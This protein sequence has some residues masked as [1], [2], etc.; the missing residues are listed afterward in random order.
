MSDPLLSEKHEVLR[1]SVR[2]FS[3]REI[4]PLAADIDREAR[5]PWETADKMAGLGY[6]GIQAPQSL[7]GAGL[8]TVSY[9]IVIEEISRVSAA[10]GLC[11]SVKFLQ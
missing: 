4:Q 6:F 7:G 5:F 2:A 9:A 3:E 10:L 1:R 8:D 11:L